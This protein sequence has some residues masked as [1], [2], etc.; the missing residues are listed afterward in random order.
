MPRTPASV[1]PL[2]FAAR[3][4]PALRVL[5]LATLPLWL[6]ACNGSSDDDDAPR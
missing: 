1:A 5:A 3:W 2:P 4:R 6:A